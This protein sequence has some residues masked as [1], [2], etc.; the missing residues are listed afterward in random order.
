MHIW[1]F[2]DIFAKRDILPMKE[3][4]KKPN[5]LLRRKDLINASKNVENFIA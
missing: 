3:E 1:Y 4:K 5:F 2:T